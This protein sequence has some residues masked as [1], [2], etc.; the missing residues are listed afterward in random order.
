MTI[1]TIA[2][3]S[4]VIPC[5]RCAS[6]IQRAIQS[7]IAQILKPA[8]VILVDDASGDETLAVLKEF[9]QQHPDW[10]KVIALAENQ[11]AASARNAGWAA[12]SHTFIAFLDADD[13]W[14]PKKIE[15]QYTYMKAHLEV[16]LSGHRHQ[17]L[18]QDDHLPDWLIPPS[19]DAV[20]ISKWGL[21]LSN[22]FV[23]PS[24]MVRRDIPQRFS[25]QQRYMEDH[26]LWLE[27]L[28]DGFLVVKLPYKLAAIYKSSFGAAGLSSNIV[29][30]ERSELYNYVHLYKIQR[31]E[32]SGLVF[33]QAFSLLKFLRR[34]VIVGA[35]KVVVYLA[36]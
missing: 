33:L 2:P 12:A 31:I 11:G 5:Y 34:L 19:T 14:H 6:T 15:I 32:L 20:C 23:T 21:L 35:R 36:T 24:I 13:A 22:K 26:L 28:C 25:E 4:V 30:M 29:A 18:N 8:E 10:I 1:E 27:I 7:V 3:V 17:I 9:E 16:T